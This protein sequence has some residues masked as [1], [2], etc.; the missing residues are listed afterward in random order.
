MQLEAKTKEISDCSE[1]MRIV[2][3]EKTVAMREHSSVYEELQ[4]LKSEI[5][6]LKAEKEVVT[7]ER[8]INSQHRDKMMSRQIELKK[9]L[10]AIISQRSLDAK[11]LSNM[12]TN[13]D[14]ALDELQSTRT[15]MEEIANSRDRAEQELHQVETVVLMLCVVLLYTFFYGNY[16]LVYV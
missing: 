13:L 5:S 6:E 10:D 14:Q 4:Q 3:R 16:R 2:S 7:N 11:E 12:K 9:K 15:T 1:Q 8:D